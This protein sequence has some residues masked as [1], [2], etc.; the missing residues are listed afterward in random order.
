MELRAAITLCRAKDISRQTLRVNADQGGDLSF[1]L[2]FEQDYKLFIGDKRAITGDFEVSPLGGQ[3]CYCNS[4]N[5]QLLRWPGT[6]LYRFFLQTTN[7]LK[8]DI[9]VCSSGAGSTAP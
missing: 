4:L 6:G 3:V 5:G 7:S 8:P 1:H 9:Q 2:S